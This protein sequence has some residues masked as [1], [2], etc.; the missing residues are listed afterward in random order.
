MAEDAED[1][2]EVTPFAAVG[3]DVKVSK[4]SNLYTP[5]SLSAK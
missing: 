1:M 5:A 3:E 2:P 4:G